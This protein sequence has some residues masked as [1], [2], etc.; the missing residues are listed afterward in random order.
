MLTLLLDPGVFTPA[1]SFAGEIQRFVEW[2]KASRPATPGGEILMPGE[3][4]E[5]TRAERLAKGLPLDD[6]TWSQLLE[7]AASVGI[8]Q[9]EVGRLTA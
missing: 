6:T 8:T 2:V 7:T 5:R 9:A 4:E 1:D 3:P